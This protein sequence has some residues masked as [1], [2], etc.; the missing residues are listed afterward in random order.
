MVKMWAGFL[1]CLATGGKLIWLIIQI[2]C[3]ATYL[4]IKCYSKFYKTRLGL[5]NGM[6]TDLR[7]SVGLETHSVNSKTYM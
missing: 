2:Q 7:N 5:N 6:T 3:L 1:L 4:E